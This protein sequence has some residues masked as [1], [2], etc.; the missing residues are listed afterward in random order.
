MSQKHKALKEQFKQ[1]RPD[2]G[3]FVVRNLQNGQCF[4]EATSDL[5]GTMNGA[6]FRLEA[7]RHPCQELQAAWKADGPDAFRFEI[8]DRL[9]YQ[10]GDEPK[11]YS[12]DLK[13]LKDIWIE[14]MTRESGTA[15]YR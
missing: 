12:D 11:D 10:P 13:T 4:I 1:Y 3:V 9:A 8:V 15:F 6:R 7:D 14:K 2:M 5:K